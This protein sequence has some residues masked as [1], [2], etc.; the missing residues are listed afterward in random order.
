MKFIEQVWHV[1]PDKGSGTTEALLYLLIAL[2]LA[3][4]LGIRAK[5]AK[6][7]LVLR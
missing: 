6:G 2:V 7:N 1:S 4:V 5:R 3:V